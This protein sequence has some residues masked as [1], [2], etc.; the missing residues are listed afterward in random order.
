MSFKVRKAVVSDAVEM[1]YTKMNAFKESYSEHF[2][3]EYIERST[4]F[5]E[6]YFAYQKAIIQSRDEM[7]V[8]IYNN[9]MVGMFTEKDCTDEDYSDKASE[10]SDMYFLPAYWNKGY[11]KRT[12][13][14]VRKA[15]KSAKHEYAVVWVPK[16]NTRAKYYFEV[17]GFEADGKSRIN[18]PTEDFSYEEIRMI[19]REELK[20]KPK[21]SEI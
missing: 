2:P 14:Y 17:C 10:I 4:D 16:I 13:R 1:A 20:A 3:A 9:I 19:R 15:V 12:F 11:G 18:K 5:E 7:Y 21:T 6:M 8:V